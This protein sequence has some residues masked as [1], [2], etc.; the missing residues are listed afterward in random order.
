MDDGSLKPIK[1]F[2]NINN[3]REFREHV[4]PLIDKE[5][6]DKED[7]E[8]KDKEDQG[9]IKTASVEVPKKKTTRKKK[10]KSDAIQS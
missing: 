1:E 3:L 4:K 7:K 2:G 8:K 10:E 9:K 6:K 5:K